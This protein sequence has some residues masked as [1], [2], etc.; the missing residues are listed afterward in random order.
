VHLWAI[1]FSTNNAAVAA[2]AKIDGG[3]DFATVANTI[4][5]ET[6]G[7][8]RGWMPLGVLDTQLGP[9]VEALQV[10]KC[11]DPVTYQQSSS[12]AGSDTTTSYILLKV[13]EK[14]DA[15]QMTDDQ[16]N[17]LK[18]RALYDWLNKQ[19][20]SAKITFH[21]LNGSTQLDSQ[22]LTWL[23]YQAQKLIQ[24]RPSEAAT[25]TAT[26][27]TSVPSTTTTSSTSAK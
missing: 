14:S 7:G 12:S 23:N 8:D 21:G 25:T 22:T 24:K 26:T 6:N 5:G 10:G 20:S 27:S 9:T 13:S 19:M 11:S 16:L 4:A 15:M 18:N 17:M 1:V 2:K 3:T